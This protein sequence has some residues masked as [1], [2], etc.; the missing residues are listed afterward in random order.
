MPSETDAQMRALEAFVVENEDLLA[1]EER[2]GRFN[3]FDALGIVRAEIRHSNFLAWLL[4][5]AESHGQGDLFLKSV[6]MDLARHARNQGFNPPFS[7]VHLDGSDMGSVEIH[8]E[9]KNID[10]L[11]LS[12]EPPFVIA[13]ENKVDS[14]EHSNQ[15]Q[16]YEETVAA[17][18]PAR[19][20]LLVFLTPDGAEA[21]DDDWVSYSYADLHRV[22]TRVK[23][24]NSGGVGPDVSAFLDH[25]LRLIES[26]MM[27][28][29]QIDELCRRIYKNH[30]AAI[31]LIIERVGATSNP[32]MA[33]LIDQLNESPDRWVILKSRPNEIRF[34]PKSWL[35]VLPPIRKTRMKD[36]NARRG[37]L[38]GYWTCR[39]DCLEFSIWVLKTDDQ[40]IRQQV[41]ER[42]T[43]NPEEFGLAFPKRRARWIHDWTQLRCERVA[44]W[45][46][47]AEP[48]LDAVLAEVRSK[49]DKFE[50]SALRIRDAIKMSLN[51]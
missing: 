47:D 20:A 39:D 10:L 36:P 15:L 31:D 27:D 19:P 8:R 30:R 17:E 38:V 21:S 2:I 7:P 41:V 4:D 25:Y 44:E 40:H 32:V 46:P 18:F 14:G 22:L 35:E 5:P 33:A 49:M 43:S 34:L 50:A 48:E 11:I 45:T 29:P 3:I 23:R 42:L 6:L 12:H 51:T 24:T 16:R 9:W 37:W 26:R 1:L 28:D 13:I